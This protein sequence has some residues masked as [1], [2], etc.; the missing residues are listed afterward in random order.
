MKKLIL[1]LLTAF[2]LNGCSNC[3]EVNIP[4]DVSSIKVYYLPFSILTPIGGLTSEEALKYDNFEISSK[5]EIKLIINEIKNLEGL[6]NKPPFGEE[7]IYLR[8][9]FLSE[10]GSTTTL[11]FDKNSF[12]IE[13]CLYKE[14]EK[15][16]ELLISNFEE[17]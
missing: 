9:D 13:N 14:S 6:K 2:I 4:N 15:L 3:G 5:S 17:N 11:L 12:K 10:E 7:N 16:I 1:L 8:A